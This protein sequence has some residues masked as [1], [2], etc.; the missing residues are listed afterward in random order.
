M[1]HKSKTISNARSSF[2][3]LRILCVDDQ[4]ENLNALQALLERWSI[5]VEVAQTRN[6]ALAIAESFKPQIVLMDYQLGNYDNDLDVIDALRNQLDMVCPACLVT[7]VQDNDVIQACKQH[8]VHYMNKPVK[9]AKLRA[10]LQAMTRH[11]DAAD[12][13]EKDACNAL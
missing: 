8:G 1:E 11:I 9:P 3:G 7:A 10:L 13:V 5:T 12:V 6:A 4:Q 2:S